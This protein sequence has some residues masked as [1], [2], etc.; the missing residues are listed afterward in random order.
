MTT[1]VGMFNDNAGVV[2]TPRL[3]IWTLKSSSLEKD[4]QLFDFGG[5]VF[6]QP[7]KPNWLEK[8]FG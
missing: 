2:F 8:G 6:Y 7:Q 4:A 3:D 1:V 5:R